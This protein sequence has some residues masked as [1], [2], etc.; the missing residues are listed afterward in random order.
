M[1]A[2]P[3]AV[4]RDEQ[5]KVIGLQSQFPSDLI[6]LPIVDPRLTWQVQSSRSDAVQVAYQIISI[7][8]AGVVTTSPAVE[9]SD[10]I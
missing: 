2:I 6:G 3:E 7:D 8:E 5:T 1:S 9:S 4:V 10:S